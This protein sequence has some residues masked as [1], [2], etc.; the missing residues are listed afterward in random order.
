MM[1]QLDAELIDSRPF[2]PPLSSLGA[3]R[4]VTSSQDAARRN[5]VAYDLSTRAVNLPS[6][7]LL[8]EEDI[9]IVCAAA[10]RILRIDGRRRSA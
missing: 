10:R 9:D 8:T 5:P 1:A 2:F 3:F 7:M 6:A 4:D